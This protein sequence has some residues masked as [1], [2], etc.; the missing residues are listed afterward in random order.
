MTKYISV[1][2]NRDEYKDGGD[3]KMYN[4]SYL[5]INLKN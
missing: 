5:L 2:Y 3:I 1:I 4:L